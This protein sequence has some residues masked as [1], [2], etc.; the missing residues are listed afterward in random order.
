M[1][2]SPD[3]RTVWFQVS[4]HH[5]FITFDLDTGSVTQVVDLPLTDESEGV[6]EEQ[7]V[8]DSAHHGLAVNEDGTKLCA[9]GTAS[10]YAAI[11][12]TADPSQF[13]LASRGSKP[14]WSTIGRDGTSCWVSYSGNDEV[15]II[16]Y[17]TATEIARVPV[18]RH[19]QRVRSG[20]VRTDLLPAVAGSSATPDPAPS[21]SA[22]PA[23]APASLSPAAAPAP[24]RP[25]PRLP[26]TGGPALLALAAVGTALA[27]TRRRRSH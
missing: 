6:P 9:A 7:Y 2:I 22:T 11:V 10:D 4:F 21:A 27:A 26:S 24:V 1:T 19:P 12:D 23:P 17:A 15:A 16:D 20:A 8:L 18:G 13:V 5:G 25:A 14:Y 3:E